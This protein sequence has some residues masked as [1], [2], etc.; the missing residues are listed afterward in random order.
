MSILNF[1]LSNSLDGGRPA[2]KKSLPPKLRQCFD[3]AVKVIH[4]K[5]KKMQISASQKSKEWRQRIKMEDPERWVQFLEKER[6]RSKAN[7]AKL[8]DEQRIRK[9]QLS[10]IR[11]ANK[12]K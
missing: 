8:T 10:N 6:A 3:T 12:K 4:K 7:H 5:P 1:F 9:Y 11:R 2:R